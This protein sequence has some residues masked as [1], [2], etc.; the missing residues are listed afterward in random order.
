MRKLIKLSLVLLV[1]ILF[2]PTCTKNKNNS[3]SCLVTGVTQGKR[4]L[5][6]TYS[7]NSVLTQITDYSDSANALT[8]SRYNISYNSSL[9]VSSV[10]ESLESGVYDSLSFVYPGRTMIT[11]NQYIQ[12]GDVMYLN[13]TRSFFLGA[14][15][16]ITSDTLYGN[17]SARKSMVING[18][19]HY[20]YYGNNNLATYT[21]FNA[22]GNTNFNVSYVYTDTII[23][24]NSYN[25]ARFVFIDHFGQ[26]NQYVSPQIYNYP[27]E[28]T[29]I[30]TGG[31]IL[32]NYTYDLDANS[33]PVA[34]YA[35]VPG[36]TS[37]AV[38][39]YY[40]YGCN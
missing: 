20:V 21:N 30:S 36:C 39:T 19:S 26:G 23:Q 17:Q 28:V 12:S 33:D 9:Q 14:N 16:L 5:V 22:D 6:F 34:D 1:L 2:L 35:T 38:T 40:K 13:Y 7:G 15:G 31:T 27:S 3:T 25:I 24:N 29:F 10:T 4:K 37:C 18:Y 32:T 8:A 11:E